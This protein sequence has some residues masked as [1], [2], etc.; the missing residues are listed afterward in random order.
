MNAFAGVP[1]RKRTNING[2]CRAIRRKIW[3]EIGPIP[4]TLNLR[5]GDDRIYRRL[6]DLKRNV[7]WTDQC[8]VHH[9]RS[10]TVLDPANKQWIDELIEQD[11]TAWQEILK[12]HSRFDERFSHLFSKK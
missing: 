2:H 6:T 8:I 5:Y 4:K 11:A 1:K 7:L 12:S 10:V 9:F 3:S